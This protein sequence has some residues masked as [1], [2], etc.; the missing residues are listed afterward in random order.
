MTCGSAQ[1]D[2]RFGFQEYDVNIYSFWVTTYDCASVMHYPADGLQSPAIYALEPLG[3]VG[4]GGIYSFCRGFSAVHV[5]LL[6]QSVWH[7][8]RS[9]HLLVSV[10]LGNSRP[11]FSSFF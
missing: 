2:P 6:W 3:Y 4:C 9:V 5:P 7:C 1:V 11:F 8:L 10:D